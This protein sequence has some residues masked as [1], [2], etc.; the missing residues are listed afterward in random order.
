[1]AFLANIRRMKRQEAE[2]LVEEAIRKG[3]VVGVPMVVTDENENE[4]W[5]APPSSSQSQYLSLGRYLKQSS[6]C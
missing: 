1:M 2:I 5:T 4:P 6:L 3:H